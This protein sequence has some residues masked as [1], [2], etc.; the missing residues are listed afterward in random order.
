[1]WDRAGAAAAG[2]EGFIV[3]IAGYL[4]MLML[5][6][7]GVLLFIVRKKSYRAFALALIL[8]SWPYAFL[9]GT[10][11]VTLFVVVPGI[12]Y[13]VLFFKSP[14]IVKALIVVPIFLI[15]E[16]ALREIV[17]YR[18]VG[19]ENIQ[20]AKVEGAQHLGLNMASE[21]VYSLSFVDRGVMRLSYGGEYFQEIVNFIP[22]AIWPDKP[23][24]GI[25]YSIA[26]GFGLPFG[27]AVNDTGVVATIAPGVIGQGVL[28]FGP[29]L[30]A[31][32]AALLMGL[33]VAFLARLRAQGTLLRTILF[34][35]GLGLTFNLG[36]G[37]TLLVLWPM[38]FGYI[39]VRLLEHVEHERMRLTK[40]TI[41]RSP[42]TE[43]R[44]IG[45]SSVNVTGPKPS[46]NSSRPNPARSSSPNSL[47]N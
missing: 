27:D 29:I 14:K 42:H 15:L 22:R 44:T 26:R 7:F 11:N 24:L 20:L 4:Y 5:A 25:D 6:S 37:I 13:Y 32:V 8:V 30:G 16:L 39:G 43:F 23:L 38:V 1:M 17:A 2:A 19:Y 3:S 41:Q 10:R 40:R 28:N 12:M 36:R 21:L 9:Q 18:D 45:R 33:W 35:L 46:N 31:I 34:L 47:S